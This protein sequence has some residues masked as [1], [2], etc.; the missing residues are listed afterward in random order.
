MQ[1]SASEILEI[2]K[3]FSLYNG[4]EISTEHIRVWLSQFGGNSNQRLILPLLKNIS[5]FNQAKIEEACELLF[6]RIQRWY[7]SGDREVTLDISGKKLVK[8]IAS[9]ITLSTLDKLGKSGM[10]IVRT[11]SKRN[12]IFQYNIKDKNK[13]EF[14]SNN[15]IVFIDDFIASG[16]T[17]ADNLREFFKNKNI[18]PEDVK[19]K[20]FLC[21]IVGF[22]DSANKLETEF[23]K[24]NVKVEIANELSE[25]DK[26]FSKGSTI[27]RNDIMKEESKELCQSKGLELEKKYPLGFSDCQS[28]IVFHDNCPNN[29][30][31]IFYKKTKDW[32]PLFERR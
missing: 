27:F 9:K 24:Y 17:M 2:Q 4:K 28:L 14:G 20:I 15:V 12:N 1:I 25:L 32:T 3:R 11:F 23:N 29:T 22:T 21:A 19:S 10:G 6:K 7:L 16:R 8:K 18:Q 5:F 13:L 31:P 30:L 26:C